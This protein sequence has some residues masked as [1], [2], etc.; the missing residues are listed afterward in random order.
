MQDQ[1]VV[2]RDNLAAIVIMSSAMIF[3]PVMDIIAKY[4]S[5]DLPPLEITLGRFLFQFLICVVLA[6]VTWDKRVLHSKRPGINFLRGVLLACASLAFFSS[7]KFMPLAT[8]MAIFFIE[9]MILTLLAALILKEKFGIR[10]VLAILAGLVGV[11]MIL[12]PSFENVGPAVFLPM[13]AATFF[14]CYLLI[15]RRYAGSDS[16]LT[17]QITTGFAGTIVL[18]LALIGGSFS[19]DA[20]YAFLM[21]TPMQILLLA[22]IGAISF[23]GHAM[24]VIAFQKAEA[25][26][27]APLNYI[28]IVSAAILGLLVF[29]DFPDMQMWIG[30]AIIIAS[31][32]YIAHRERV[33]SKRV[34]PPVIT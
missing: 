12:S 28:E 4:L 29:G 32:L 26:L 22:I 33:R 15:N 5:S 34:M 30:I 21:P 23:A 27:L 3:V 19:G 20:D 16:L 1:S 31:G 7:L 17:I 11:M 18:G 9:P 24:V 6:I 2:A 13:V 10:R 8:A 25:S 14:A